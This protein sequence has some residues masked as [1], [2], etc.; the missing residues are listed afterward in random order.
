[1]SKSLLFFIVF[2]VFAGLV[3]AQNPRL[4]GSGDMGVQKGQQWSCIEI[5]SFRRI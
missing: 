1:M 4:E 3:N 2:L 5:G